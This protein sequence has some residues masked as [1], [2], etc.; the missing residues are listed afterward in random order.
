MLN[1]NIPKTGTEIKGIKVCR[2]ANAHW[3][4]SFLK[5][6]D[7][8]RRTYYWMKG[9]FVNPD[10]GTDTDEWALSNGFVSVVPTQFD[11]TAHTAISIIN[12]WTLEE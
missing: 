7:P 10:K 5:R 12:T 3:D 4:E 1:V 6:E 11:L 2:Q 8:F 9:D